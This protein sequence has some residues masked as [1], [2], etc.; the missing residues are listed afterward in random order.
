VLFNAKKVKATMDRYYYDRYEA[1]YVMQ[2]TIANKSSRPI[3]LKADYI[4]VNGHRIELDEEDNDV[5]KGKKRVA[6]YRFEADD[7]KGV[8][9]RKTGG[10][11]TFVLED[12]QK[13][14]VILA[15]KTV[16]LPSSYFKS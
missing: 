15:R 16:K 11:I 8:N 9:L 12:D 7:L 2:V 1:E 5:L 6:E 10:K 13:E 4:K 14:H 3:E